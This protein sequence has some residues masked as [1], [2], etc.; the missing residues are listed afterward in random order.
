MTN[1]AIA[2]IAGNGRFPIIFAQE[3]HKQGR[4][5]TAIAI[6]EETSPELADCVDKIFWIGVGEL[7]KV[8]DILVDERIK[9]VVM[10]GQI[11][12][13][14]LFR[15]EAK[16]DSELNYILRAIKS[17]Q[18]YVIFREV[19]KRL[20][21]LGIRLLDSS[22]YLSHLLA[23][24]GVIT[25]VKPT[26]EQLEDIK[27]GE[28]IAKKIAHLDIGQT[29]VIRDKVVLAVEAI[30]GTDQAIKRGG[31]LA[32]GAVVV[33]ASKPRHDMRFDIP[34]VGPQTIRSMQ[35]ADAK[36]L[37]IEAKKSLLIDKDQTVGL[38][39]DSGIC[40]TVF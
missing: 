16:P 23:E 9:E 34:V 12:A 25:A 13:I 5:I 19:S 39:D 33:K 20:S 36:C 40:I 10:A 1:N 29:V 3:T 6:K 15:G 24:K 7:K 14:R 21:K 8:L 27:F 38:A 11:K 30:E 32:K 28:K 4:K 26:A 2:L 37:A 35:A 22:T 17:R 18:P 31:T